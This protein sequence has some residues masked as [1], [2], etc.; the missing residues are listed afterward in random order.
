[1]KPRRG[2][3]RT[4]R[5]RDYFFRRKRISEKN[6]EQC[7]ASRRRA[8]IGGFVPAMRHL[9]MHSLSW[10]A[11]PP[12]P[13]RSARGPLRLGLPQ[14]SP[15]PA[16]LLVV[17]PVVLPTISLLPRGQRPRRGVPAGPQ[18]PAAATAAAAEGPEWGRGGAG[19]A[20]ERA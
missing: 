14:S 19:R 20:P 7:S 17:L 2:S 15:G 8:L 3:A 11:A 16:V 18:R 1:M 13:A 10:E 12:P 9:D 4:G 6:T 5:L